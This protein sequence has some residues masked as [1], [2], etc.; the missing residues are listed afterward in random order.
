MPFNISVNESLAMFFDEFFNAL[1][2]RRIKAVIDGERN[3]AQ[4]KFCFKIVARDMNV[5]RLVFF[6]TVK[7]KTIWTDA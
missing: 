5:R 2:F 3:R 4:P 1:Q 6:A 7:M